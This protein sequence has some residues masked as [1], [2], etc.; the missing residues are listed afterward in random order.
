[1]DNQ[2]TIN[3]FEEIPLLLSVID[4]DGNPVPN[5]VVSGVV[6][7]QDVLLGTIIPDP[8]DPTRATFVPATAGTT[9]ITAVAD[10]TVP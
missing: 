8:H 10:I 7:N 4:K 9:H 3:L 5:A 1:M 6:G 2:A